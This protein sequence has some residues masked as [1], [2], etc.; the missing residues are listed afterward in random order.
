[1]EFSHP[2]LQHLG[3]YVY[4]LVDPGDGSI[5]YIGKASG[6]NRPFSHLST[7]SGET[8]KQRRIEIIRAA[9]E[10]PRVEILRYGLETEQAA[11][12]VEAAIIDSLGMENLTNPVRGHDTQRGRQTAEEI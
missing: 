8:E 4:A 1:M 3:L 11:L 5:F 6:S 2:T 9:G 12:D 10:E 7:G